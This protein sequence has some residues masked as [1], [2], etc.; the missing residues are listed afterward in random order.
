MRK[1]RSFGAFCLIG[2]AH[3]NRCP[4]TAVSVSVAP[5]I[6]FITEPEI[7]RILEAARDAGAVGAHYVVLRMPWEVNPLFHQWLYAHFPDRA[8]RVLNRMK[9]LEYEL[10]LETD[11]EIVL[12]AVAYLRQGVTEMRLC[13]DAER[14][15]IGIAIEEALLN[16]FYHG[17]LEVKALTPKTSRIVYTLMYDNSMLPD[18]A[19]RTRDLETRR[20]TF[21]RAMNNM[22]ILAEG[23]KLPPPPAPPA[24]PAPAA[25]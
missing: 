2:E 25:K 5:I 24:P 21:M 17:N 4:S 13:D 19:A 14:L 11:L 15:R 18:D 10:E 6:P 7:E 23:G 20:T 9:V 3:T 1:N 12:A 8:Q 16:A 22:K